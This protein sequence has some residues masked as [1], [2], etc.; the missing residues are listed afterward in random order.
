MKALTLH[1]PWAW[2]IAHAGKNVENRTWA[3]NYRGPLAIHA[4]LSTA[5]D[6][7][8]L[9]W[10]DRLQI[11][12]PRQW[13]RGAIVAVAELVG[14]HL[15]EDMDPF[16][17]WAQG[18]VCWCLEN[19]RALAQPIP[20]KGVQGL[21]NVPVDVQERIRRDWEAAFERARREFKEPVKGWLF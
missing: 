15:I 3:T 12:P 18:P 17:R 13:P 1:P 2:A 6:R 16:N 19:V 7:A 8:C 21:W 5:S 10:L 20:F 11:E 14:V 4:G 9:A